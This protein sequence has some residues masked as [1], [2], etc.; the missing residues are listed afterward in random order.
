[1]IHTDSSI[2]AFVELVAIKIPKIKGDIMSVI[3]C[4]DDLYK[5]VVYQLFILEMRDVRPAL[6]PMPV[7][8]RSSFWAPLFTELQ[9]LRTTTQI[10]EVESLRTLQEGAYDAAGAVTTNLLEQAA[11]S[12]SNVQSSSR[13][14]LEREREHQS[15]RGPES[16]PGPEEEDDTGKLIRIF[17]NYVSEENI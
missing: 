7:K 1:M 6:P 4:L 17:L 15:G 13:S 14:F 2:Y 8:Y 9:Q 10:Y 3:G 11:D 12:F 16:E 5:I